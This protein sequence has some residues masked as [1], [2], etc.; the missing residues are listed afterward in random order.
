MI[1]VGMTNTPKCKPYISHLL[2]NDSAL[3]KPVGLSATGVGRASQF[4][5]QAGAAS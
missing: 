2:A 5:H 1:A 3:Q 4:C